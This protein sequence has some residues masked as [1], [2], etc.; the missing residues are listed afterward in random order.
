MVEEEEFSVYLV[1]ALRFVPNA[2]RS[3]GLFGSVARRFRASAVR[4]S[5]PPRA[6]ACCVRLR[7]QQ[8]RRQRRDGG[9]SDS[10]GSTQYANTEFGGPYVRASRV[11]VVWLS[12]GLRTAAG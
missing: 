12:Y 10:G 1:L 5:R 9:D 7:R 11:R 6:R 4:L 8:Q 2:P 3:H